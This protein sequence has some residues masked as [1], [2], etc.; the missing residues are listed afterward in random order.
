MKKPRVLLADDHRMFLAGLQKLLESDFDVVGAVQDG[1]E[2]LDAA[3]VLQP[4]VV[5]T[6]VSM[7]SLNGIDAVRRLSATAPQTRVVFLSM[8]ADAAFMREAMRAGGSA[9]VLKRDAPDQLV[10]A[11]H[12]ALRGERVPLPPGASLSAPLGPEEGPRHALTARQ[13]EIL[14]LVAEGRS[15]KEIAWVLHLSAKTVEFHKYR[16]MRRLG[17]RSTAELTSLAIKHGL[18]AP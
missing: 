10:G 15:L 17:A 9:Y 14:Q 6:D 8:H 7:P 4:D 13:C 16:L 3:G 11:I 1:R 12:A 18:I 5:V 2:L